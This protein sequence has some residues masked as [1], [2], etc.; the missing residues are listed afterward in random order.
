[1][2]GRRAALG[3]LAGLA[4]GPLLALV[5]AE[6]ALAPGGRAWQ[7]LAARSRPGEPLRAEAV[8]ARSRPGEHAVLVAGS[9]VAFDVD[10]DRLAELGFPAAN[11][12]VVGAPLAA[13]AMLAPDLVRARPRSVVL[14]VGRR[15]LAGGQRPDERVR[16][17]EP[18]LA[19]ELF[20][21]ASLVAER[22][23]HLDGLAARLSTLVRHR[24]PI[25]R[26]LVGEPLVV[27]PARGPGRGRAPHDLAEAL[28]RRRDLDRDPD[29]GGGANGR[30]L[31]LLGRELG[32]AGIGLL[33]VPAPAHPGVEPGNWHRPT[34]RLLAGEASRCGFRLLDVAPLG[35][36]DGAEFADAWHLGPAGQRR[37]TAAVAAELGRREDKE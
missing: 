25:R 33:V 13:T 11:L 5:L 9:S 35:R 36:F 30:A 21:P 15:S 22:G 34:L 20:G 6:L 23:A 4:L 7:A 14:V 19:V 2:S 29:P 10:A 27:E 32:R 18:R 37:L 1:L 12:G 8:L 28:A 26:W 16:A 24:H 17:W 3:V 31:R